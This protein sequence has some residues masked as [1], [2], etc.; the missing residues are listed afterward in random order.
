MTIKDDLV[1]L[2]A[3]FEDEATSASCTREILEQT[4][5]PAQ[6]INAASYQSGKIWAYNAAANKLRDLLNEWSDLE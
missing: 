2:V 6:R 5:T 1:N 3:A 4:D